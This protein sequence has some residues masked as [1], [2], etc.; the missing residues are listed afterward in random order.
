MKPQQP[1]S[2]TALITGASAGLGAE[3]ARQLAAQ[4]YHL[5]LT[6]RRKERL[7]ALAAQLSQQ[8][9]VRAEVLAADL[10]DPDGVQ[11]VVDT[12]RA[13]PDLELL[14]NNAGFGLRDYFSA[15]GLQKHLDMI[16]VHVLAVMHLTHAALPGMRQRGRGGV[17]NVSSMAAF[18]PARNTT[19]SA[20]KAYLVNFSQALQNELKGSGVR[21]QALCPGFTHTEFH[22]TAELKDKFRRSK[23][24]AILWLRAEKVV[25]DSLADLRRGKVVCVPGWVYN[26]LLLIMRSGFAGLVQAVA[27][28]MYRFKL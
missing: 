12:I 10:A 9:G 28:R 22:E 20:T 11:A 5:I 17:I 27:V 13:V 1:D 23:I 3:F 15:G 26:L 2:K 25:S 6:A 18:I 16:Q 19:Y 8:Y 7:E 21:I 24:P 4:G 14:V